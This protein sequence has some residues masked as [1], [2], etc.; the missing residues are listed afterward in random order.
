MD[1]YEQQAQQEQQAEERRIK[2]L[3][4]DADFVAVLKATEGRRFVRRLLAECG[5]YR[6]SF[7]GDAQTTAFNEG[8]RHVGLWLTSLFDFHP[9]LYIQLLTE[10]ENDGTSGNTDN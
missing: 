3:L 1:I 2:A 9:D 6:A 5:I 4:D 8:R 7:T 10:K